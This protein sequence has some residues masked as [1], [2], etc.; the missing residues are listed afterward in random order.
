[1]NLKSIES[2]LQTL[3]DSE[4]QRRL[5]ELS[6]TDYKD[7]Y[8]S[9][10]Q[11]MTEQKEEHQYQIECHKGEFPAH[12]IGAEWAKSLCMDF[13]DFVKYMGWEPTETPE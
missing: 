8:E 4:V 10:L 13:E 11:W 2:Q 7:R 1:M 5:E 3:I 9:I 12:T 6:N